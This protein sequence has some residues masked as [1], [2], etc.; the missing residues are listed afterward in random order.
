MSG[1][2]LWWHSWLVDILQENLKSIVCKREISSTQEKTSSISLM[3]TWMFSFI[4]EPFS[5]ILVKNGKPA[6]QSPK[7][8]APRYGKQLWHHIS[9]SWSSTRPRFRP[10]ALAS[11]ANF[12]IKALG[13][14]IRETGRIGLYH[15]EFHAELSHASFHSKIKLQGLYLNLFGEEFGLGHVGG[16]NSMILALKTGS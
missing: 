6:L 13:I 8:H 15:Q 3:T 10:V 2:L 4:N 1:C 7:S 9:F 14:I 12:A 16:D 5:W 11:S